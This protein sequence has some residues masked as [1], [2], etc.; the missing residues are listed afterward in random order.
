MEVRLLYG[1]RRW[2]GAT[3]GEF[4]EHW[5]DHHV[6]RYGLPLTAI[7]R[8]VLYAAVDPQPETPSGRAPY[9][10]VAS[11]W[12]DDAAT[13]KRILDGAMVEAG[14][15]EARFIDHD[16]SRAVLADDRVVVEPDAPA[17]VV[18]AEFLARPEGASAAEFAAA[19]AAHGD[20]V[21]A[22]YGDGLLQGYVQ[23]VVRTDPAGGTAAFDALGDPEER[24]DGVGMAYFDSVVAA[25]R[26]IA[27]AG[28]PS[29]G[30]PF[31][32]ERRTVTMLAR[33][34]PRR[35]PIR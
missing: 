8:Y 10:G 19:W 6:V 5:L 1:L 33:R 14:I 3:L 23:S 4:H 11:V 17:P 20:A 24:W 27:A 25:R 9:D 35:D 13:L 21:R 31:A 7:R 26:Y 15:D 12:F 29:A 34:H 16:R 22:Q 18:L 2:P 30:A 32:D 28:H